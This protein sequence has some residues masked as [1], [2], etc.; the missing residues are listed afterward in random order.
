MGAFSGLLHAR[1]VELLDRDWKFLQGDCPNAESRDCDDSSWQ[2]VEV[3][4]DWAID[5]NFDMSIDRQRVK[6]IEDGDENYRIR[7][8]RTGALPCFGKA[9]YRKELEIPKSAKGDR[10]FAEFDGAM[11]RAKVHLNG[12]FMGEWP[13][14]YASFNIDLTPAVKYGEKNVLAVSLE[15]L[16]AKKPREGD[17]RGRNPPRPPECVENFHNARI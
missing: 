2:V 16:F 9:W 4:H 8:G 17:L 15:R 12:Q 7:T 11:S 14:G 6:V 1:S 10:I 3:P 5:K 13:Y